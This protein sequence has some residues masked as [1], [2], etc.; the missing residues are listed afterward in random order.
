MVFGLVSGWFG[1]YPDLEWQHMAEKKQVRNV[2]QPLGSICSLSLKR[3][4]QALPFGI[5]TGI[6]W[7]QG[8]APA[9]IL[10]FGCGSF[11]L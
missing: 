10:P 1:P 3:G 2:Y 6:F 5:H 9:L 11:C 8:R 4:H 7:G